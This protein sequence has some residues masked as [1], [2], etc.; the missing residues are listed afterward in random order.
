[1]SNK[2]KASLQL[3]LIHIKKKIKLLMN[4]RNYG[5][6][7]GKSKEDDKRDLASLIVQQKELISKIKKKVSDDNDR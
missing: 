5:D 7:L 3:E 4:F 2:T 1:M 6:V